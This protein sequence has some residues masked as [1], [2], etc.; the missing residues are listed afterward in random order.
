LQIRHI[1]VYLLRILRATRCSVRIQA[2][3]TARLTFSEAQRCQSA[4]ASKVN[5]QLN[6]ALLTVSGCLRSIPTGLPFLCCILLLTT[7]RNTI[8]QRLYLEAENP[9]IF[10]MKTCTYIRAPD[11]LHPGRPLRSFIKTSRIR[12]SQSLHQQAATLCAK[13]GFNST[14]WALGSWRRSG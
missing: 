13:Q 4:H 14:D 11:R 1:W 9:K 8:Y 7:R 3:T 12:S 2:Q 10:S 5:S 6:E